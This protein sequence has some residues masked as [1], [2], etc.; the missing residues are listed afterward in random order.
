MAIVPEPKRYGALRAIDPLTGERKWEIAYDD[1]GWAGVLATAGGVVFSGD[2]EGNFFAADS[3]DRQE[4]VPV[5]DRRGDLCAADQLCDRRPAVRRDSVGRDI[6]GVRAAARRRY[7][8]PGRAVGASRQ[9]GRRLSPRIREREGFEAV[10][11]G[12]KECRV[13]LEALAVAAVVAIALAG[14]QHHPAALGKPG[15]DAGAVSAA[16]MAARR[17]AFEALP[18]AKAFF[19]K[20][21]GGLYRIEIPDTWNGELVLYAHGFVPNAGPQGSTLRVG[22]CADSAST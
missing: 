2:H 11:A 19:G 7:R 4:A 8:R 20:Y 3:T 5:P 13:R 15:H 12:S 21:D 18:G 16:G 1:A 10:G 17:P 22:N 14:S 6:D 9:Q